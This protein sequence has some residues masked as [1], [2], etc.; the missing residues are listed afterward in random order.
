MG[1]FSEAPLTPEPVQP[2]ISHDIAE[3][4]TPVIRSLSELEQAVVHEDARGLFLRWTP[5]LKAD[6]KEGRVSKNLGTRY[7]EAGISVHPL[8][9]YPEMGYGLNER[10]RMEGSPRGE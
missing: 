5:D 1:E 7:P 4:E 6:Q 10:Y 3:L 8:N 9:P 2:P